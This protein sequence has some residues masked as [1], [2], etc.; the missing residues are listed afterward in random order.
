MTVRGSM[1]ASA[2]VIGVLKVFAYIS[3]P[4]LVCAII[5]QPAIAQELSYTLLYRMLSDGS[6]LVTLNI[7]NATGY[8]VVEVPVYEDIDPASIAVFDELG[9]VLPYSYNGSHIIIYSFNSSSL[10]IQYVAYV[11]NLTDVVVEAIVKPQGPSTILLPRGS[12]L[13]TFN[14][15]PRISYVGD[16]ISLRYDLPGAYAF[17]YIPL[18]LGVEEEA[19]PATVT[20]TTTE[21]ITMSFTIAETET[22]TLQV[23]VPQTTTLRETLTSTYTSTTTATITLLE[24]A[25]ETVREVET[26]TYTETVTTTETISLPGRTF[27]MTET[28]TVTVGIGLGLESLILAFLAAFIAGLLAYFYAG[29]RYGGGLGGVSVESSIVDERDKSILQLLRGNPMNIS[30]LSRASGYSK[31]TVWRRIKRLEKMGLVRL[32]A[33]GNIVYVSLTEDGEEVLQ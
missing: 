20:V 24:K 23:I 28:S 12:A 22:V 7:S 13:L 8:I 1:K 4:V 26:K 2:N 33:K 14:G 19:A 3:L 32:E 21:T 5:L 18:I 31:S 29:R 30:E 15:T 9:V 25:T 17:S 11:G 27:T 6:A 10:T 16:V